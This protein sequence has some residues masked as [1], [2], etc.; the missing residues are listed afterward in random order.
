[1][2]EVQAQLELLA[3]IAFVCRW[4]VYSL[5]AEARGISFPRT[6]SQCQEKNVPEGIW[7][8][9]QLRAKPH[10]EFEVCGPSLS[11]MSWL[12]LCCSPAVCY[13]HEGINHSQHM[14]SRS[15]TRDTQGTGSVCGIWEQAAPQ[16]S[17]PAPLHTHPG[18]QC[19]Q[20]ASM[21]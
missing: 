16:L 11:R 4:L 6:G 15:S 1:M 13:S 2:S 12:E 14:E 5:L 17:H 18:I 8:V 7:C 21:D 19:S 20:R 3:L 9:G 10:W